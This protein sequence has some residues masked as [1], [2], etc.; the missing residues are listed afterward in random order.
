MELASAPIT[1]H[2]HWR[3]IDGLEPLDGA[4]KFDAL[5]LT[6]C[7]L[8]IYGCSA[9]PI[10]SEGRASPKAG[11]HR[12]SSLMSSNQIV[13]ENGSPSVPAWIVISLQVPLNCEALSGAE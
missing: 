1:G 9:E 8:I 10:R 3:G 11:L 7:D 5:R 12:H 4:A 6:Q 2:R 13:P